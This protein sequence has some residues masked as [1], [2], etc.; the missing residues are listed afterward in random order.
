MLY[1][2]LLKELIINQYLKK[3]KLFV[4]IESDLQCCMYKDVYDPRSKILFKS[5]LEPNKKNFINNTTLISKIKT[6][7]K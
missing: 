5:V 6:G 7:E 1:N 3:N 2:I 4:E